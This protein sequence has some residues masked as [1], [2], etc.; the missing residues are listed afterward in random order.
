[1]RDASWVNTLIEDRDCFRPR[2]LVTPSPMPTL[3]AQRTKAATTPGFSGYLLLV[4]AL[5]SA[6]ATSL[7]VHTVTPLV[8][9]DGQRVRI[10]DLAYHYFIA[11]PSSFGFQGVPY[12]EDLRTGIL[13]RLCRDLQ[14]LRCE[15]LVA[16]MPTGVSPIGFALLNLSA[17]VLGAHLFGATWMFALVAFTSL[18][19]WLSLAVLLWSRSRQS[20]VALLSFVMS[21]VSV[22]S[23][24]F[25]AAMM[26]GQPS[27]LVSALVCLGALGADFAF[28]IAIV[29]ASSKPH[30]FVIALAMALA[31]GLRR[32]VLAV[33]VAALLVLAGV[34]CLTYGLGVFQSYAEVL[35]NYSRG[36]KFEWYGNPLSLTWVVGGS[37]S[38]LGVAGA[39]LIILLACL[40]GWYKSQLIASSIPVIYV[41]T[42]PYVGEYELMLLAIPFVVWLSK[43]EGLIRDLLPGA[44]HTGAPST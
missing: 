23:G 42:S 9:E 35:V 11:N 19:A 12:S 3:P 2:M 4:L 21:A 5:I 37:P 34:A 41:L 44:P 39:G 20:R 32:E 8:K 25:M 22:A 29:V 43:S 10:Q 6:L 16:E 38:S 36:M 30:Y 18:S 14:P 13:R 28:P 17:R 33:S 31:C 24:P 7:I 40:G 15:G 1:M 27:V 26:L